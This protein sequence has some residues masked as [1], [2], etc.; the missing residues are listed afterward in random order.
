MKR[1]ISLLFILVTTLIA[2]CDSGSLSIELSLPSDKRLDPIVSCPGADPCDIYD[3][4]LSKFSLRIKHPTGVS[5]KEVFFND[6]KNLSIGELPVDK[7]LDL[8]LSG[9]TNTG[10]ILGLGRVSRVK[11]D[12]E[13]DVVVE[14]PFRK[15]M[16]YFIGRDSIVTLD[17]AAAS[18]SEKTIPDINRPNARV[19]ASAPDGVKIAVGTDTG[20]Y[21]YS[22]SN[23]RVISSYT[24][25]TSTLGKPT[26]LRFTPDS[27]FLFI[28][29]EETSYLSFIDLEESDPQFLVIEFSGY[30]FD[31]L[32]FSA[33]AKRGYLLANAIKSDQSCSLAETSKILIADFDLGNGIEST[34][35][36][37]YEI[38]INAAISDIELSSHGRKLYIAQPCDNKV[39]VF[40]LPVTEDTVLATVDD[41]NIEKPFNIAINQEQIVVAGSKAEEI[42]IISVG[43]NAVQSINIDIPDIEMSIS[44]SNLGEGTFNWVSN[45][46]TALIVPEFAL[47]SDGNRALL[48]YAALFQSDL[49]IGTNCQFLTSISGYGF[50]LVDLSTGAIL[51]NRLS[52]IGFSDPDGCYA[53]CLSSSEFGSFENAVNCQQAFVSTLQRSGMLSSTTYIPSNVSLLF[54]NN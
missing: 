28:C 42:S 46:N 41:I 39:S 7:V 45:V 13:K 40:D 25:N 54:G 23:H 51:V 50:M 11:L 4:R 32:S 38:G 5:V 35:S 18:P 33:D 15:P 53:N 2:G 22:T 6:N 17:S 16:G 21:L 10:Q 43:P 14:L 19:M 34:I 30:Q 48:L 27:R 31:D 9:M 3:S 37:N 24:I 49:M 26:C 52:A 1:V 47:S 29:H 12:S 20:I 44:S 8:E 36:L